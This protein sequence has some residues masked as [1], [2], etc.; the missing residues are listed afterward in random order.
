MSQK[1]RAAIAAVMLLVSVIVGAAHWQQVNQALSERPQEIA[2][3]TMLSTSA[4]S[5]V[6]AGVVIPYEPIANVANKKIPV[7]MPISGRDT[8]SFNV[9]EQV[10]RTFTERIGGDV[11]RF[12]G[13][14]FGTVTR[15]VTL[16]RPIKQ[17]Y[18][19]NVTLCR[20]TITALP[21]GD[22]LHFE[23]PLSFSGSA[24]FT[25]DIAKAVGLNK[26]NFRGAIQVTADVS[27]SMGADWRPVLNPVV[28][29]RWVDRGELE[30]AG[31]FWINIQDSFEP[32][33]DTAIKDGIREVQAML[34]S[35]QIKKAVAE[36]W[37]P[38]SMPIEVQ[39]RKAAYLN[40]VPKGVG[41]S[42]IRAENDG[43][44]FNFSLST[45]TELSTSPVHV[46]EQAVELPPLSPVTADRFTIV[47]PVR[48]GYAELR[49]AALALL[50]NRAH[51]LLLGDGTIEI[52]DLTVYPT[53]N[54]QVAVGVKV[55][56]STKHRFMNTKGWLY[57]TATP[58]WDATSK[59]VSLAD[60]HLTRQLDNP[61]WNAITAAVQ[62]PVQ[63]VLEASLVRDL[64]GDI[65]AAQELL[66][67]QMATLA[68][69]YGIEVRLAQD[70]LELREVHIA[71]DAVE[72]VIGFDGRAD[73][74]IKDIDSLLTV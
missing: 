10:E 74:E 24:G 35:G 73:I 46:T 37:H 45:V 26:K 19:Y 52:T 27:I 38:Y 15:I 57:F 31:K 51:D 54:K 47:A 71:G 13:Q 34:D 14:V 17:D 44:H 25:G 28:T 62:G 4:P 59:T 9:S 23:M 67:T 61:I 66:K 16:N 7:E 70:K 21:S 6:A 53:E 36:N 20:G 48:A 29:Y 55:D 49:Q 11:G 65:A 30:V 56:V 1:I 8:A 60:L 43:L 72:L 63:R 69:E 41:L 22:K 58:V 40:I 18:N 33:L 64:S 12:L 68:K 50:A 39:G 32:V 2:V 42:A 3:E 5:S